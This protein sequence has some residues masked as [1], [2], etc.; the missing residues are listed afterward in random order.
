[1]SSG[2]ITH[3]EQKKE[4]YEHQELYDLNASTEIVVALFKSGDIHE[5]IIDADPEKID[6][7]I[8]NLS[9]VE[10]A[11]EVEAL[12]YEGPVALLF[13]KAGDAWSSIRQQIVALA[14]EYSHVKFIQVDAQK[15]S[16][17]TEDAEINDFPAI[18]FLQRREE[19][20]RIEPITIETLQKDIRD[21]IDEHA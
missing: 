12:N 6:S 19:I 3:Q 15:L 16:R 20:A 1:M 9:P 7:L 17:I 10:I 11:L 18:I 21:I 13:F 8:K 2:C 5:L 4:M 14:K